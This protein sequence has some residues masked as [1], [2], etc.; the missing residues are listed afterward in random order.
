MAAQRQ[1]IQVAKWGLGLGLGAF[2]ADQSIFDVDGGEAVVMFDRFRGILDEPYEEGT[3][4]KLP[5]TVRRNVGVNFNRRGKLDSR[6][7]LEHRYK[8]PIIS[9]SDL[10]LDRSP[11]TREQ[12]TCR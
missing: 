2:V 8:N 7:A 4:F 1:L 12:K 10:V 11:R 3:H 6:F 5:F 9:I